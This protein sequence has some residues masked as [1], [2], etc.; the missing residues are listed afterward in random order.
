MTK[1]E[2][3]DT[4]KNMT[5]MEL[6]DLVKSLETEFGISAVSFAPA[7]PT[8]AAPVEE[9][10]EEQTEFTVILKEIGEN[11]INVIKTVREITPL[12]LKDAKELV[13]S[14]PNPIKENVP[15]EEAMLAK[16][17]LEAVGATIEIK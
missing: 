1:E 4:I 10:V 15:K 12:G 5:V 16:Q 14:A 11:K 8:T 7:A 2:V 9:K 13:E 6:A 17:K 3:I